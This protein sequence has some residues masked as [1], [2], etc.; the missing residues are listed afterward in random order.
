MCRQMGE[1]RDGKE[2]ERC[3]MKY[4]KGVRKW[5][6]K[7]SG[8][9]ADRDR[10]QLIENKREIKRTR[11]KERKETAVSDME[12]LLPT[13]HSAKSD[14]DNSYTSLLLQV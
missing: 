7:P 8:L 1:K 2:K 11:V 9:L 14:D 12:T 6:R 4:K 3:S 10:Q 13:T 5:Q